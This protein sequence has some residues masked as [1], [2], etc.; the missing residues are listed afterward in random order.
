MVRKLCNHCKEKEAVKKTDY[1]KNFVIP[2]SL[3]NQYKPKGCPH[4]HFSGYDG[5]KAIYE[6]IPTSKDVQLLIKQNELEI[7]DYL[8]ENG[9]NTIKHNAIKMINEG[10]TSVEEVFSLLKD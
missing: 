10:I 3:K 6:I 8:N 5:R 7:E 9:I 1:P 2:E 4:C